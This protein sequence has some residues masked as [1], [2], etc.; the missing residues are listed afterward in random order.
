MA[1]AH[2]PDQHRATFARVTAIAAGLL[3]VAVGL[4][5]MIGPRSFFGAVAEFPPYN[6]HFRVYCSRCRS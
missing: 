6:Q 3:F 2:Q 4:W 1:A 5:A